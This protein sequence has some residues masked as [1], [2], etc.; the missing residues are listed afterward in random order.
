MKSIYAYSDFRLL[1]NDLLKDY[2]S[3]GVKITY[4]ELGKRIG[5]SSRGFVTQI[6]QG[7]SK[8]PENKIEK[9]SEALGLK[10]KKKE[11]FQLLVRYDQAKTHKSKNELFQKLTERFKTKIQH[12]GPEHFEFYKNWYYSA[13]RSL[14]AYYPFDGDYKKLS[15][16]LIP[17]ITTGQAKKAIRL[18]EKLGLIVKRE[19][20]FFHI[21][22]RILSSGNSVD[23]FSIINY[24]KVTMDLA[25]QSLETFSKSERSSSTLTLG[26]SEKGYA[27]VKKKIN[28]LRKEIMEIANYDKQINQVIQL[29][30]HA[31]PLTKSPRGNR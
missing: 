12:L 25:K 30:I 23:A 21:T 16:Q 18:L 20:G 17:A 10:D 15:A 28:I 4:E 8:I 5:F 11:Y 13:I 3:K 2:K 24:Q 7:K 26:L 19:D 29:N 1:I 31:F 14:L 9:F 27:D 22:G 6:V